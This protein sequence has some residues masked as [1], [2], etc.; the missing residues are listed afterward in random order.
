MRGRVTRNNCDRLIYELESLPLAYS[1][2]LTYFLRR[3]HNESD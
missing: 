1:I 2:G 3:R